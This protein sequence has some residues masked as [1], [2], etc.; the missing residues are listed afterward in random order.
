MST[1]NED[2][3]DFTH[4]TLTSKVSTYE[5]FERY[6]E[7]QS[8]IAGLSRK[9]LVARRWLKTVDD[10]S[11]L[12]TIF[13]DLPL[14]KQPTLFRKSAKADENLLAIWQARARTQAEY[15]L[16]AEESPTFAGLT[17]EHLRKLA[18]MS[19]DPQVVRE[20]P[21][22]LAQF[23][24]ILVYVYALPGMNSDGAVFHLRT[25]HPVVAMSLRFPRLDY[26]WFTLLHELAH[27]VLHND[28][29]KE[30]VFFDV[31]EEKKDRV[32]KGANRLAKDCIVDRE[33]WRNCEPK[34]DTGDKALR[35]YAAEQGVHPALVAG[36]LRKE[37]GNYTRYSSIINEYD[38]REIIF[39][40]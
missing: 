22:T 25:N 2:W 3:I 32:E 38:V 26:F 39:K 12:A 27:L 31:E 7:F 9:E 6:R 18:R 23:G 35:A 36:L 30:P 4:T 5:L 29:L 13:F 34:Y 24:I 21:S 40:Q 14:S 8:L 37:S 28:Q 33:S 15:L 16:L 17:K 20:L 10:D 19:V 11:A 1:H